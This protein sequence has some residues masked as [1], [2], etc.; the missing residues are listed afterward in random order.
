MKKDILGTY[1]ISLLLIL[2]A[3]YMLIWQP[4]NDGVFLFVAAWLI[5]AAILSS[6]VE[7]SKKWS[8]LSK[9]EKIVRFTSGLLY[10]ITSILT[11][12][13]LRYFGRDSTYKIMVAVIF[14]LVVC[15]Y[16]SMG[17][18]IYKKLQ[19]ETNESEEK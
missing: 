8:E 4:G 5:S 6:M 10:I 1:I 2:T 3:F 18:K 15:L 19:E 7:K 12:I 17:R 9:K 11:S 13:F 16:I 14:G